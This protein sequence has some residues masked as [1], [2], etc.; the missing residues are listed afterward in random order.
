MENVESHSP[1][2]PRMR[3]NRSVEL[4]GVR[5][6]NLK[7][8]DVSIP[9]GGLTVITGVS[10]SG[11]SSLAF[12]TL[13]TE[14]QRRYVESFPAD[15]RRLLARLE[16]PD[17]DR[18]DH[19]PPAIAF[20]QDA[21]RHAGPRTTVATIT[22]VHD[23]L[24][25]LFARFGRIVCPGCGVTIR[26]ENAATVRE[27]T[28]ALPDGTRW[29]VAFPVRVEA[30]DVAVQENS[31]RERG[32]VR[33]VRD[34]RAVTLGDSTAEPAPRKRRAKS[35]G[36]GSDASEW[37]VV[38]DRLTAG[39]VDE[40]RCLE[41]LEAA[42]SHGEGQCVLLVDAASL[43]NES[44]PAPTLRIDDRDWTVLRF[45]E[46]LRCGRCGIEFAEPEPRLFSFQSPLGAC[47]TC[48][49]T[50]A[51]SNLEPDDVLKGG[52]ALLSDMLTPFPVG[53]PSR[54]V[55]EEFLSRA[56][57]IGVPVD[58]EFAEWTAAD[59]ALFLDPPQTPPARR[60]KGG[61]TK[62][63]ESTFPGLKAWLAELEQNAHRPGVRGLLRA[64]RSSRICPACRGDRLQPAAL[65]V[66]LD[67]PGRSRDVDPSPDPSASTRTSDAPNIAEI[68]R[69]TANDV[70]SIVAALEAGFDVVASSKQSPTT[71]ARQSTTSSASTAFPVLA[72]LR[73]RLQSLIDLGLGEIELNR[74]LRST[75]GGEARRTALAATLSTAL[76]R[77]LYVLDEPAGGMHPLDAARVLAAVRALRDAGNT[78]VVVEH[79]ETFLA[80]ADHLIE[81][82]PGAG[83]DGG[84]VTFAGKPSD[85]AAAPGTA[86]GPWLSGERR[87]VPRAMRRDLDES[88][89]LRLSGCRTNDL[90]GLTVEFPLGALCV[91]SGASGTGK[92]SLVAGSLQSAANRMLGRSTGDPLEPASFT[93]VP[94]PRGQLPGPPFEDVALVDQS[95]LAGSLRSTPVTALKAFDP[96]RTLFAQTHDAQVRNYGPSH[97]AFNAAEGRCPK[98]EGTGRLTIDM[99][100]LADVSMTCPEC[101]GAR[102]QRE[103]LQVNYRGLNVAEVL[104]MTVREAWTFFSRQPK[105]IR[106]LQ[107]LRDVGLEYLPLG[108]AVSTLSGGERQRLKLAMR[109][110]SRRRVR[111]LFLLDE[112]TIGLHRSDV[113][114]LIACFDGLLAVGHSLVVIENDADVIQAADWVIEL[115]RDH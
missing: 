53:S 100:F 105:V 92:T 50:G 10:G 60:K 14:G 86:T 111:T 71:A 6:H 30:G 78:V 98:C 103:I 94:P 93:L 110:A 101:E 70:L 41:S 38:V 81:I 12:D 59:D 1:V 21:G 83:P 26:H 52:I 77:A 28:S 9:L 32:F 66:R 102:Y 112:P 84:N 107:P 85:L 95:P 113:A 79:D 65:A 97:F 90:N 88:P 49:G 76:V 8:I 17:A 61:S 68:C 106:R 3:T 44:S 63:E 109:L 33:I 48:H 24:R 96:I 57:A 40:S 115:G 16:R 29:Q 69:L 25:V 74:S 47:R 15:A 13:F 55:L 58:R 19:V 56:A 5:V 75:S 23:S 4:R 54:R 37:L 72:E 99:Q 22:E 7:S 114:T 91:V 2:D 104:A 62:K 34:G 73:R 87:P 27:R 89:R 36:S 31:L 51:V 67:M 42:F 108:Q 80:A 35:T 46:D 39:R 82:G 45:F 64:W 43:S 11:K 18:I 20:R